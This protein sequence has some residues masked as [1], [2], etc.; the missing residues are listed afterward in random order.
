MWVLV[1]VGIDVELPA[2]EDH[3][4]RTAECKWVDI[5][6][7]TA[8]GPVIHVKTTNITALLKGAVAA[9]READQ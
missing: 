6:Y 7:S 4:R 9:S 3:F 2:I 1:T 5:R 8:P